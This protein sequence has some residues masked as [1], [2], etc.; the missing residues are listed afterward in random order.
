MLRQCEPKRDFKGMRKLAAPFKYRI[1]N[2][3]LRTFDLVYSAGLYDYIR[4]FE[5]KEKGAT[6][7]TRNLFQLLKPGGTLLIGNFSPKNP[8]DLRFSMELLYD[9]ILI[10]RDEKEMYGLA[11]GITEGEI[12]EVTLLEEPL[13]INYFLKIVKRI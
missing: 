5:N 8:L 7:L 3:A 12:A 11:D 9:W 10:Y 1:E 2:L 6:A 4:T 13:G